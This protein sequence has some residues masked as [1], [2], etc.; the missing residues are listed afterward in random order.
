MYEQDDVSHKI[1]APFMTLERYGCC[2]RWPGVFVCCEQC[3]DE[4]RLHRGTPGSSN[5]ADT[6]AGT[7]PYGTVLARSVVPIAGGG[8]TPTIEVFQ[9]QAENGLLNE[10]TPPGAA[11]TG[12]EQRMAVVEGPSCFGG[13][14]M[15]V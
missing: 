8:C 7:L 12:G 9:R 3:Q 1:G 13:A 11:S 4:M 6:M 5:N 14:V 2:G 10:L 15:Y